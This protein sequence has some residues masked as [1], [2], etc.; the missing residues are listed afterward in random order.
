MAAEPVHNTML[1]SVLTLRNLNNISSTKRIDLHCGLHMYGSY[2]VVIVSGSSEG[3]SL[4]QFVPHKVVAHTLSVSFIQTRFWLSLKSKHK[5]K[6]LETTC[7]ALR[8]IHDLRAGF[9][10]SL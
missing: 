2:Q 10:S 6:I 9:S 1:P 5:Q 7:F 3:G 8:Y 4:G